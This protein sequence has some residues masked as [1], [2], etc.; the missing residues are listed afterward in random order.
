MNDNDMIIDDL[1][2]LGELVAV[3]GMLED[4]ASA[5]DE[6]DYHAALEGFEQALEVTRRIFGDNLELTELKHKIADIHELL[7]LDEQAME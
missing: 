6:G 7:L 3:D 5:I 2:S 4:A 1:S